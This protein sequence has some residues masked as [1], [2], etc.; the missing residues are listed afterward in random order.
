M[1]NLV[2]DWAD[3]EDYAQRC[4]YGSYQT[5]ETVDGTE[6]RVHVGKFGYIHVFQDPEDQQLQRIIKFCRAEDFIKILGNIP[7][8][9]LFQS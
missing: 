6:I 3:I 5:R 4:R 1:V 8:E 7:D 9:Q 2:E